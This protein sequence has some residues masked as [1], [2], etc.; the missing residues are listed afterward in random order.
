MEFNAT[1]IASAISF[2]VFVLIMNSIFY[3]PLGKIVD[4]RQ[5]FLDE[6]YEQAALAK[7]KAEALLKEKAKKLEVSKHNAKKIIADK[8]DSAKLQKA[9]LTGDAQQSA[10]GTISVAKGELQKSKNEAQ[11]VLSDQVVELAQDISSKVLG[12][13]IA[14]ENVD[15][16]LINEMMQR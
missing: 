2:I 6:H 16:N 5:K 15:K 12:E 3:K 8:A 11:A 7:E 13:K 10:A 4:D 14:I 9:T 1:F